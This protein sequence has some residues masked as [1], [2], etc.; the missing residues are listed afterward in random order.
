[1]KKE[2]KVGRIDIKATINNKK[3]V[4]IEIQLKDNK[5]ID[6]RSE[7]Y[8]AKLITEQLG[9]GDEYDELKP[10]ILINILNYEMLEVPE[11]CTKTVTVAEKHR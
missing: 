8:G 11:Y 6:K 9:K 1:M 3:V 10:V 7:F 5:N 4:N 2:D